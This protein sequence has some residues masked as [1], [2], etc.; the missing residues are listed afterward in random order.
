MFELNQKQ[1]PVM[2]KK[3]AVPL[4]R[5]QQIQKALDSYDSDAPMQPK[6]DHFKLAIGDAIEIGNLKDCVVAGMNSDGTIIAIEYHDL[7]NPYGKVQ[8][9][10]RVINGNS[11]AWY[12]CVPKTETKRTD[13]IDNS[14]GGELLQLGGRSNSTLD[15]L[16]FRTIRRGFWINE[17]Y[18]R[19]YVWTDNDKTR[20]IDSIFKGVRIGEF[21]FIENTHKHDWTYEVLDGQQRLTTLVDFV[22]SRFKYRGFYYHE[23]S[24]KDRNYF[25][26]LSVACVEL[27][28]KH[29]DDK[30]KAQIFLLTNIAGVPQIEEH[31]AKVKALLE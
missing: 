9:N 23:L 26:N 30:A 29:L 5:E 1:E 18:Q 14:V 28:G 2:A 11:W 13:F 6:P 15:S 21:V 3:P 31:L 16:L 17:K 10:G 27:N 19:G 4:T 24:A 22:M 8:D 12:N 7:T 25:E 20:L